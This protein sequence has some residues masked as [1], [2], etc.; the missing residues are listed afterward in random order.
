MRFFV[1]FGVGVFVLA[2]GCALDTE[3][4][5]AAA[6]SGGSGGSLD[7]S[8]GGSGGSGGNV[9]AS[10]PG[11]AS[12]D[13]AAGA[14]GSV[15]DG[16]PDVSPDAVPDVVPEAVVEVDCTDGIDG[17]GDGAPDCAD[18]DC[19]GVVTCVPAAPSAWQGLSFV[20]QR[21]SSE[22]AADCGAMNTQDPPLHDGLQPGDHAC[23]C[24]CGGPDGGTCGPASV[25]LYGAAS[26]QGAG[27]SLSGDGCFK[28]SM[29]STS[30]LASLFAHETPLLTPPTCPP[31]VVAQVSEPTWDET[32][33]RCMA[34]TVAI[35]CA[36][37][38]ACVPIPPPALEQRVCVVRSGEHPC[39][40]DFPER[41]VLYAGYADTR[42]C[43]GT[44][45]ACASA[46]GA[47]CGG[48][49]RVHDSDACKHT[50]RAF[51][52][53]GQCKGVS[54][55]QGE[56]SA[57]ELAP[58]GVAGG[59]CQSVGAGVATGDVEQDA[60]HTVCCTQSL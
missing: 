22:P 1:P 15:P 34:P 48:W 49:V 3:G 44:G 41:R 37:D 7:A 57:V 39:P 16:S 53:D 45:C 54:L 42:G 17:D 47:S 27:A 59:Q 19:V 11:D 60:A 10:W 43:S 9:D 56:F 33:D 6:P 31:S 50:I 5:G 23:T 20:K 36:A 28:L 32:L 24:V 38:Q 21:P 58:S 40:A 12:P 18:S 46:T 55:A 14:S 26:C 2:H 51:D 13:A 4:Q 52:L 30:G 25:T 35:G 8:A 29:S